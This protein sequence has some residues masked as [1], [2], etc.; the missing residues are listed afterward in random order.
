M[1]QMWLII[2]GVCF[3]VEI[4]TVG[5]LIFW[6]AIGA[7]IA[8]VVSFFTDSIL[9]Q[10]TIFLISSTILMFATKP[11]V[12][13]LQKNKTD[14]KTNVYSIVGSVGIVTEDINTIEAKGQIKVD[15]EIWSATSMDNKIIPK[16]TQV[17]VIE[18][19]GVKAI[20]SVI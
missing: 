8:M 7:L 9:I 12:H 20:V 1:W 5:F 15:G 6:F 14:I 17:E 16:G 2:S 18:I 10:T 19:K 3:I 13:K 4:V 11:L